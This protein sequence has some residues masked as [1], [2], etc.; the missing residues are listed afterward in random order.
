MIKIRFKVLII[1][2]LVVSY[3]KAQTI[4][5]IETKDFQWFYKQTI[6]INYKLFILERN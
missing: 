2:V 5:P 4:I 6:K 1:A 3:C